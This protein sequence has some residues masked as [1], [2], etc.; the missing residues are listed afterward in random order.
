M[1]SCGRV[2]ATVLSSFN[3]GF[4][5]APRCLRWRLSRVTAPGLLPP[6]GL[7]VFPRLGLRVSP[8][9]G[10]SLVPRGFTRAS[11]GIFCQ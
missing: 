5:R 6:S 2:W 4:V 3:R 8:P 9:R 1:F 11:K 7:L 10:G